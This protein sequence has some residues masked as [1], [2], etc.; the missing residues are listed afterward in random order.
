MR[1]RFS[2]FSQWSDPPKTQKKKTQKQ[3]NILRPKESQNQNQKRQNQE[4]NKHS[5]GKNKT[6][7]NRSI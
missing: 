4:E 7:A 2:R 5:Q 1:V 6:K 3:T